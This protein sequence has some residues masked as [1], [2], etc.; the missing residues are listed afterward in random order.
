LPGRNFFDKQYYGID[1]RT[2]MEALA[3]IKYG[4][5]QKLFLIA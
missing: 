5:P 1:E 4:N 2:I 3:D